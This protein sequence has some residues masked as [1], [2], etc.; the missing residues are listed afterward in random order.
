MPIFGVTE[1]ILSVRVLVT[2]TT[3][4]QVLGSQPFIAISF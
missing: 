3:V 4:A 1:V 2:I